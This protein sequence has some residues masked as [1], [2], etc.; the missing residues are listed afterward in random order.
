MANTQPITNEEIL[1]LEVVVLFPS[2]LENVITDENASRIKAKIIAELANGPTTPEADTILYKNGSFV[3]PDFLCN[4][5]GV[6]VSYFEQVQNAYNY[7][8]EL[9]DVQKKLDVKMTKAFADVYQMHKRQEVHMRLAAYL[10]A[11]ERV[12]EAMKLRGW[13]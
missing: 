6:T 10:V 1:E 7:Y 11:V 4:A 12:A 3:I 9:E 5:G 13:V 2:A 8:W